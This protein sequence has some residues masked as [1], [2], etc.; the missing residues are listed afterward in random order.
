MRARFVKCGVREDP[1]SFD[2]LMLTFNDIDLTSEDYDDLAV[3]DPNNNDE[4]VVT[5]PYTASDRY[6]VKTVVGS[7][8]GS[9]DEVGDAA[10]NDIAV[11]DVPQCAGYCGSRKDGCSLYFIVTDMDTSPYPW[12]NLITGIKDVLT[13]I[14][15]W[16]VNPILGVPG[17][18]EGVECAGSRVIVSSNG[19]T[20]IAYND[21]Y[22]DYG[23]PDQDEWNPVV[24]THAPA[25]NK[26]ALFARTSREVWVA[27]ADGYV[28]KST[29]AGESF[30]YVDAG[31]ALQA[32]FAYDAELVYAV[33]N[34][35][36][37]LRSSDGG[38][39]WTDITSV[40]DFNANVLCV[41]VP[42]GRIQEVYVGTAG[43]EV[44]R[45]QNQGGVWGHIA[46]T[47]DG[48]GTVDDLYFWGDVGDV[49]WILHNNAGPQGRILRDLS[50][51]Y[52]G[53]DVRVEAGYTGIITAG[54]ELNAIAACDANTAWAVGEVSGGYP[55]V[56]KVA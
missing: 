3:T 53:P 29:D 10:A 26:N 25:A 42:P 32:I 1:Q 11:C 39:T 37:M 27:C 43:G 38:A 24:L 34:N 31:V 52:G 15:T 47:G 35:G 33:G 46:F 5:T 19:A 18:V 9:A 7:R 30:T 16:Y 17:N 14:V 45:S 13:K 4:I 44:W 22:D 20:M 55:A 50:G 12:P 2:P 23:V 40:A 8:A 21:T 41:A 49:L 6:R 36:E 51:G 54:V 28:A 48:V 56:F